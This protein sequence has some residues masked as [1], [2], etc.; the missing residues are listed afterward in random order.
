MEPF[1]LH[2]VPKSVVG[3]HINLKPDAK[4]LQSMQFASPLEALKQE[5]VQMDWY[6]TL[7]NVK[8]DATRSKR[9]GDGVAAPLEFF[10]HH[11]GHVFTKNQQ[12][13]IET[14]NSQKKNW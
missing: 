11:L 7:V 5:W 8:Q 12:T 1:L 3:D 6:L 9:L 2:E 14:A 10:H 4:A 13:V